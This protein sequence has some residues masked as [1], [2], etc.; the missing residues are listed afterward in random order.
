MEQAPPHGY[1]LHYFDDAGRAIGTAEL[2]CRG[3]DEALAV[4]SEMTITLRTELWA[5]PRL[6]ARFGKR[7]TQG[8]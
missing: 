6:L 5:G 8:R 7:P 1:R 3:D 2:A 4:V